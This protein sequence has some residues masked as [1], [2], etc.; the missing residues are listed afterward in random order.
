M[1]MSV[2][3]ACFRTISLSSSGRLRK[4]GSMLM[5]K[6]LLASVGDRMWVW[7][8]DRSDGLVEILCG[9]N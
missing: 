1:A 8:R 2:R 6:L 5:A 4:D 9:P 7:L 3:T